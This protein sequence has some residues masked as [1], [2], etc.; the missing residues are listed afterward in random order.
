MSQAEVAAA[1]GESAPADVIDAD[2]EKVAPVA[3][4]DVIDGVTTEEEEKATSASGAEASKD[5]SADETKEE[6]ASTSDAA[7]SDATASDAAATAPEARA[8]GAEQSAAEKEEKPSKLS[9]NT[10]D[11]DLLDFIA[12][13]SDSEEERGSEEQ[14]KN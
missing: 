5:V 4:A 10:A 12:K 11:K 7:A 13:D 3:D 8:E 9:D 1:E 14:P 6:S 2:V